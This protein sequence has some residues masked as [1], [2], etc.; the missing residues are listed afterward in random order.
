MQREPNPSSTQIRIIQKLEIS[1]K[2]KEKS[3]TKE[4]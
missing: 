1:E 2:R 4:K 3:L